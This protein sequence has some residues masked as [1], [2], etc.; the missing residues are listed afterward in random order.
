M[1]QFNVHPSIQKGIVFSYYLI[2]VLTKSLIFPL[3]LLQIKPD[4]NDLNAHIRALAKY[5][6]KQYRV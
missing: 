1:F 4:E 6:M 3:D 5:K 2:S